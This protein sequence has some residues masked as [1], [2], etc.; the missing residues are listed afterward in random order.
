[1]NICGT[2]ALAGGGGA[3]LTRRGGTAVAR[4]HGLGIACERNSSSESCSDTGLL[5]RGYSSGVPGATSGILE[6]RINGGLN[7]CVH[8]ALNVSARG[9]A[10]SSRLD[11][12][13]GTDVADLNSGFTS[14][15]KRALDCCL[16]DG[17]A[18]CKTNRVTNGCNGGQNSLLNNRRRRSNDSIGDHILHSVEGAVTHCRSTS[19][20]SRKVMGVIGSGSTSCCNANTCGRSVGGGGAVVIVCISCVVGSCIRHD[21]SGGVSFLLSAVS[22]GA[23]TAVAVRLD[24]LVEEGAHTPVVCFFAQRLAHLDA[25]VDH[26]AQEPHLHDEVILT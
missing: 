15:H 13:A 3:N 19:L 14:G 16:S 17:L 12:T 9:R 1:L 5:A 7:R 24:V 20:S 6:G 2:T 11:R 26:C 23:A 18:H 10:A 22:A 25:Q 4:S 8:G 21:S